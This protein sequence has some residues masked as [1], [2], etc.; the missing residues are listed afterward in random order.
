MPQSTIPLT[1]TPDSSQIAGYG[2]DAATQRLAV[3]FKSSAF[4]YEYRDVSPETAAAMQAAA[5]KG[6]FVHKVI[7][8]NHDFD[9]MPKAAEADSEDGEP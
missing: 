1:Y 6:S 3:E 4:V 2:Y 8:P 9:R 5:S 7:K